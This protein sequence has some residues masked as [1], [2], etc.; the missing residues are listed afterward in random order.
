LSSS[1]GCSGCLPQF[2]EVTISFIFQFVSSRYDSLV[3][4]NQSI[5]PETTA[6]IFSTLVLGS[7]S[8]F[9][10]AVVQYPDHQVL[11]C[12]PQNRQQLDRLH[13]LSENDS[14]N[15]DFWAEP[16]IIGGPVDI[17]LTPENKDLVTASMTEI[18]V[19]CSTMIKDVQAAIDYEALFKS[20]ADAPYFESYHTWEEV[21]TYIEGLVS[22][23]FSVAAFPLLTPLLSSL[24][25]RNSLNMPLSPPLETPIKESPSRSSKSNLSQVSQRRLSGLMVASTPENGSLSQL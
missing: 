4:T 19:E 8:L 12:F 23:F 17:L 1:L 2:G 16:R 13:D 5:T 14:L 7:L 10:N 20:K 22:N 3:A 6:M 18:G 21:H 24:R 11:R 9:A 15:W 25:P